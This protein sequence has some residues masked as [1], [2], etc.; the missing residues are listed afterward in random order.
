MSAAV[1]VCAGRML[2]DPARMNHLPPCSSM[3][4]AIACAIDASTWSGDDDE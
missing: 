1:I 4:P 3:E 2:D